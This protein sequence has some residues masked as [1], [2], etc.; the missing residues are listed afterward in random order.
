MDFTTD[1][2]IAPAWDGTAYTA[3]S[4]L[5]T[6]LIPA[7]ARALPSDDQWGNAFEIHSG[8]SWTAAW[9]GMTPAGGNDDF[10]VGS[11]GRDGADGWTDVTAF[12]FGT[13][14]AVFYVNDFNGDLISWNGQFVCRPATTSSGT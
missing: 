7:Y 10:A 13:A 3:S 11:L 2:G 14:G 1:R 8:S 9:L 12:N 5:Y 4:S 6:D